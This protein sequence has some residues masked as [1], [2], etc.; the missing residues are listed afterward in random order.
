VKAR[1]SSAALLTAEGYTHTAYTEG[2]PCIV[3]PVDDFFLA[4]TV[5]AAGV[6]CSMDA[7]SAPLKSKLADVVPRL[8]PRRFR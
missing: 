5:P 4:G 7:P 1:L 8:H 6:R 3:D 2:N